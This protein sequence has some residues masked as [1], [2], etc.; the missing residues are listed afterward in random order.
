MGKT[1]RLDGLGSLGRVVEV[2]YAAAVGAAK[3]WSCPQPLTDGSS[4]DALEVA[5]CGRADGLHEGCM[6]Q[7]VVDMPPAR[8]ELTGEDAFVAVDPAK[9][10]RS[11]GRSGV[12]VVA[13][14]KLDLPKRSDG[15]CLRGWEVQDEGVDASVHME[16]ASGKVFICIWL[17]SRA[18][19]LRGLPSWP[20]AQD[21][22][23]CLEGV[24]G[25]E[26][27]SPH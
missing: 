10:S 6:G 16:G 23:S 12:C 22:R 20:K 5:G 8:G 7:E 4:N 17:E 3:A 24:R 11:S 9:A 27:R 15:D 18:C 2:A 13:F 19:M 26:S 14:W 21:L 25:F 1:G